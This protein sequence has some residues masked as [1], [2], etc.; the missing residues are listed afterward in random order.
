ME[1]ARLE[2][3]PP[4]DPFESFLDE[5]LPGS[6]LQELPPGIV[7][8][9]VMARTAALK[10]LLNETLILTLSA[11]ASLQ[12]HISKC[13]ERRVILNFLIFFFHRCIRNKKVCKVKNFQVWVPHD[14]FE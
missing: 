8:V 12:T 3:P 14:N 1:S 13:S 2:L 5:E 7:S 4:T 10:V 9:R 11:M 6:F